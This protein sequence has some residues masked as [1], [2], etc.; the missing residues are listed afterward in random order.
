VHWTSAILYPSCLRDRTSP[1]S[2]VNPSW[3]HFL[4]SSPSR[5]C[6]T[7]QSHLMS[8]FMLS[9]STV[10]FILNIQGSLNLNTF[11]NVLRVFAVV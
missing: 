7:A 4:L 1:L 5:A 11:R 6:C 3:F 2:R 9:L 8:I 10:T